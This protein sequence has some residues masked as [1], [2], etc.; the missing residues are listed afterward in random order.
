MLLLSQSSRFNP[1]CISNNDRSTF[2]KKPKGN[3]KTKE[4][5]HKEDP[6]IYT[7][8]YH[9]LQNDGRSVNNYYIKGIVN[10]NRNFER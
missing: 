8:M 3:K 9:E 2:R 1:L 10:R 7:S 5:A 4:N 6:A